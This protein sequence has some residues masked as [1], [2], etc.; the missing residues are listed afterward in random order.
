MIKRITISIEDE[1]YKKLI[2]K[3]A[4]GIVTLQKPY[5][6]SKAV[7]D[8]LRARFR[9]SLLDNYTDSVVEEK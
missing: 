3:K 8:V 6:F 4:R 7:N 9:E 5:S 1:V 2:D